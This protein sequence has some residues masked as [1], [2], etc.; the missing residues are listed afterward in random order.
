[1]FQIKL[2]ILYMALSSR[3]R[4]QFPTLF[5]PFPGLVYLNLSIYLSICLYID[6]VK[7]LNAAFRALEES[8]LDT[9]ALYIRYYPSVYLFIYL[10]IHLSNC[11]SLHLLI[12]LAMHLPAHLLSLTVL[13][14]LLEIPFKLPLPV[15]SIIVHSIRLPLFN[16]AK[17]KECLIW[18]TGLLST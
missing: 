9:V 11:S 13:S 6:Q 17:C 15:F 8:V 7:K 12:L 4:E 14:F 10:S 3:I 1:M 16:H 18:F 2:S 5:F